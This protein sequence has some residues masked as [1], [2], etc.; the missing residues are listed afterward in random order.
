GAGR[1][2]EVG[3]RTDVYGLGAILYEALTRKPP[4]RPVDGVLVPPSQFARNLPRDLE[5]VVL[6]CLEHDPGSR[7]A[8]AKDLADDLERWLNGAPTVARPPGPVRRA[9]HWVRRNP[10]VAAALALAAV[11]LPV[12][13]AWN[14]S[15]GREQ[16]RTRTALERS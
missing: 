12:L 14:V 13:L 9:R 6:K 1:S 10:W 7:Y 4:V 15:L 16:A 11:L 2:G 8:S 5:A 3:A